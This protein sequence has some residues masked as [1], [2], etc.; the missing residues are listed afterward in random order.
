MSNLCQMNCLFTIFSY[1]TGENKRTNSYLRFTWDSLSCLVC[2]MVEKIEQWWA[3]LDNNLST[4]HQCSRSALWGSLWSHGAVLLPLRSVSHSSL[5]SLTAKLHWTRFWWAWSA[6][7]VHR[8]ACFRSTV[9]DTLRWQ[10]LNKSAKSSICS[11]A[12]R[13]GCKCFWI[14]QKW[15][16]NYLISQ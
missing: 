5:N 1:Y 6:R 12:F 8:S 16:V 15:L 9:A 4:R 10:K 14:E 11:R 13:L 2:Q 3:F 7:S